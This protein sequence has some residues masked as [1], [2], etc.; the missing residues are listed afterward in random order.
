MRRADPEPSV[1]AIQESGYG[2]K[3][4]PAAGPLIVRS[5]LSAADCCEPPVTT[6]SLVLR[7]V[8]C[9]G[10]EKQLDKGIC[11]FLLQRLRP[12]FQFQKE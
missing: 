3:A 8:F 2:I 1:C 12:F 9:V 10:G 4:P 5:L 6:G 11:L 7:L